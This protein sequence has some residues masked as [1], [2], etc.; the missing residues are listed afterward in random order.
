[1]HWS[2]P[3]T[4]E[5]RWDRVSTSAC[6]DGDLSGVVHWS[7]LLDLSEV[8]WKLVILDP[9]GVVQRLIVS[10]TFNIFVGLGPFIQLNVCGVSSVLVSFPYM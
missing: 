6:R 2:C 4:D 9:T 8:V 10:T 5:F 3:I 1:M 7:D